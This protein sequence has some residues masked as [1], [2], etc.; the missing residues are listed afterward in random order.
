[1]VLESTFYPSTS[2]A[3]MVPMH[4]RGAGLKAHVDFAIVDSTDRKDPGNIQFDTSNIPKVVGADTAPERYIAVSLYSNMIQTVPIRDLKTAKSVKWIEIFSRPINVALVNEPK[5]AAA[6]IDIDGLETIE[7][8]Q[9]KTFGFVPF[10]LGQSPKGHFLPIY[11]FHFIRKLRNCGE[12]TRVI[13]LSGDVISKLL[14]SVVQRPER[15][16][17]DKLGRAID[18][19]RVLLLGLACKKDIDDMCESPSLM[20]ID[21]LRERGVRVDY[22]DPHNPASPYTNEYPAV[23]GMVSVPMT[24][25]SIAFCAAVLISTD[26]IAVDY[27]CLLQQGSDRRHPQRGR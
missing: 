11:P 17:G 14:R 8:V 5:T 27:G 21:L 10:Y 13:G 2:T 26:R 16:M 18:V 15:E 1:M 7:A 12:N 22:H 24:T 25:E 23:V 4:E 9:A 6:Y 20:L 3:V 19:S